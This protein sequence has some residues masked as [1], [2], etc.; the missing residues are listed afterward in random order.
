[1][2]AEPALLDTNVLVYAL[3]A[4]RPEHAASLALL[5]STQDASAN[6]VLAPQNLA[7]FY[8]VVTNPRRVSTPLSAND[9]RAEVEK[10]TRLP[11]LRVLDVPADL[12]QRWHALLG[13]YPVTG[14]AFY[15]VQLV[16][17]MLAHDIR[18]VYTFDRKDFGRFTELELLTPAVVAP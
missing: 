9:A 3:F 1:M 18:R 15:D 8:A 10:L 13:R 4:G 16:A 11:G 6:L 2:S 17:V 5:E 12:V 14:R 7:E